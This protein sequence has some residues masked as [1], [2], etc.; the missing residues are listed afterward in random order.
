MDAENA[1]VAVLPT[2][3]IS[4]RTKHTPNSPWQNLRKVL[5]I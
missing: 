5:S 1:I 2:T 4:V 3:D